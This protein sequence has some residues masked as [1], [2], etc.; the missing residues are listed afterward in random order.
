MLCKN[1]E[2]GIAFIAETETGFHVGQMYVPHSCFD[3]IVVLPCRNRIYLQGNS[4]QF[5][6]LVSKKEAIGWNS[7]IEPGC[8][9]ICLRRSSIEIYFRCFTQN[10]FE[11]GGY[12]DRSEERRVGK[13]C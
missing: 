6:R 12:I 1:I 8:S 9:S 4:F 3:K 13:E 11:R 5:S 10:R 7:I 2:A